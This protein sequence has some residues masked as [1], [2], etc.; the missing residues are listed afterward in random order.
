MYWDIWKKN[1]LYCLQEQGISL[2]TDLEDVPRFLTGQ[3][4]NLLPLECTWLH[5]F[6]GS[7]RQTNK[8]SRSRTDEKKEEKNTDTYC[9]EAS[10]LYVRFEHLLAKQVLPFLCILHIFITE[11]LLTSSEHRRYS[12]LVALRSQYITNSLPLFHPITP[13][14]NKTIK[15][16]P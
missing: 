9:S 5:L 3:L 16:M 1:N 6:I 13:N 12:A 7:E 14:S 8:F 2:K 10:L 4:K 15:V 11:S